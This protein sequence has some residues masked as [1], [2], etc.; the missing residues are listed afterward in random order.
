[1]FGR[2][3]SYVIWRAQRSAFVGEIVR[4]AARYHVYIIGGPASKIHLGERVVCNGTL[5][6][7]ASGTIEIGDDAFCGN[8]VS[9]LAGTHDPTRFG[10]A[11][12]TAIPPDGHDIR[13][14]EGVWLASNVT[15]VGPCVIGDHAVV[16][17]GAVVVGD[18]EPYSVVAG[19]PAKLVRRLPH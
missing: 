5:F 6:N 11:R 4:E 3:R 10:A 19:V 16:A 2:I 18:V 9:L 15:V 1:M 14:G 13:V 12:Q 17:A 7:V 8:S